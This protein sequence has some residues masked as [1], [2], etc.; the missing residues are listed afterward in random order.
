MLASVYPI[1]M[2]IATLGSYIQNGYIDVADYK[3]YIIPYTPICIALF[4]STALIPLIFKLFKRYTLPVVSF[5]GTG[6]FFAC[7]IDISSFQA[8]TFILY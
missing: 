3:K 4:I 7:F 8:T 2:G 6:L 5:W 1:Y